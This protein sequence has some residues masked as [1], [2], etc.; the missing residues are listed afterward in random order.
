MGRLAET[1]KM[2]FP[3]SQRRD[4]LRDEEL[5]TAFKARYHQFKLLL[6]ANSRALDVMAEMEEALR[7]TWPFGMSFVR[8]RCTSVSTSVFQ[9]VRHVN[10]LSPGKYEGL[11]ERFKAIQMKINPF[12]QP[13]STT[14]NG[15]LVLPL[16]A[17][18][19]D[20]ADQVGSK[21]ANLGEIR[22]RIHL[23]VSNGFAVTARAFQRF[24]AHNDLQPEINRRIQ[25]AVTQ[26]LDQMYALSADIQQLIIRSPLPGDL[27]EAIS[28]QYRRL[29]EEAGGDIR[30]AVRSS[31]LG[32][33]LPGASFAGQ[34]RTE[35]NVNR[36]H[37]FHAYRE[38][39]ASKYGVPAMTYRLNRGIRD[40]DVAMCVGCLQMV[41]AVSGGV[42]YSRNP[43][44]IRDDSIVINSVWGLPKS[45][46]DG[47][48]AVDLFVISRADPMAIIR[49]E[50]PLKEEKFVCYPEEGVCQM[51]VTGD[52][53]ELPSLADE[54]ALELARL[55]V[56][57]ETYYGAPQDIEWAA[58]SDGSITVL[59]CR[60]LR[61]MEMREVPDSRAPEKEPPGSVLFLGGFTASP[62]VAAGPVYIVNKDADTL[63]FPE[64]G[65]LATAQSLP[66]WASLLNRAAAVVTGR[67]GIAG[68]LANVAR[69]FGVPALFGVGGAID[70]L[71]NG[72]WITV[73]ADGLRIYDGPIES[74]LKGREAS[75]NLM[76][77]SPVFEALRGA[78]R[79]IIPLNLLDPDAPAFNPQNCMTFH[80]ITRF[81][82][83]KVVN[84]MFLFGKEH[85]FPERS[86]KQL[87]CKVPMQWWVLNLDDGFREE[88][89]GRYVQLDNI[90]STPM[91]AI[92]EGITAVPW[93]GPPPVD[94]KGFV[95]IMFQATTNRALVPGLRSEYAERN[96]FMVS[97]DYCNLTSRLGFH[98]STIEALV[99]DRAAENYITFQFKGGAADYERR[100]RRVLFVKDILEEYGFRADVREDHLS[101]RLEGQDE[102]SMQKGL[103][104]L[105]YLT[106][107][108]RQLDM[109]MSNTASVNRY[110]SGMNRDIRHLVGIEEGEAGQDT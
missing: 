41:D 26:R 72:Q 103:K 42:A 67:G 93:K 61:Q 92:W 19:K 40:E 86:S 79:H 64:G 9:M 38:V 59:Q 6:N 45:V 12:L 14:K 2:F 7:G 110:R 3:G 58:E 102:E 29:E 109:I 52:R 98:F 36:E 55:A 87:R 70:R 89:E 15:P 20:A 11:Y 68:H 60:P 34:Y 91:L 73:D 46:V 81:C 21:V 83:E 17:V 90:A 84:E 78:G 66:R 101:A 31:A 88:V 25:A 65:V 13:V 77:G 82:H 104:I 85:R 97:R 108:T 22:N 4:A 106:M 5:R 44:N 100:R 8:S 28:G 35:L 30:V 96:Y 23:K 10:E 50:I 99:S 27:E 74:L 16:D 48:A 54:K 33:D 18:D 76:E 32:E 75:R 57:L 80:D 49:K 37:L 24:M 1:L 51:D 63:Q 107:H 47:I 94:G 43:V 53:S 71:Q 105:G 62:G 95:S 69:E 39:V 56:D